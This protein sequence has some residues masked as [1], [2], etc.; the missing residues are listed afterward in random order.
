MTQRS[1]SLASL[2]AEFIPWDPK[3]QRHVDRLI[4]QRIDCGWHEEKPAGAWKDAQLAGTKC[5]YWIVSLNGGI[6][7][8]A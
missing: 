1:E 3:S 8:I 4:E 6:T 7:K 2:R 5:I